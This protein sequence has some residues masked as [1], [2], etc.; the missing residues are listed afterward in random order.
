MWAAVLVCLLL[1]GITF[2]TLAKFHNNMHI[3]EIP[4]SENKLV[5]CRKKKVITL[6][7]ELTLKK[8]NVHS[9]YAFMK[10]QIV[11]RNNKRRPLGLYIFGE[12]TNSILYTFGMLLMVSLPKLPTGWSIRVLTG[13]YWLYCILVCVSYRASLTAILAKSVARLYTFDKEIDK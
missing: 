5:L 1:S 13:W 6:P 10:N 8:L 7:L 11:Q 2:Y 4:P 9:K 12:V 3:E